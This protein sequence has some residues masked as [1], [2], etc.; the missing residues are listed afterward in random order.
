VDFYCPDRA[1][2]VEV[3]G[4]THAEGGAHPKRPGAR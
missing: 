1:L 3:D 4:E 2:V